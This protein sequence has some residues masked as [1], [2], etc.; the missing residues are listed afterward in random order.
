MVFDGF[1]IGDRFV[2]CHTGIGLAGRIDVVLPDAGRI[3]AEHRDQLFQF[4][5]LAG[6]AHGLGFENERFELLA[7]IEAFKVV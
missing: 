2:A 1:P 7:A 4:V 6:G 5:A 3:D